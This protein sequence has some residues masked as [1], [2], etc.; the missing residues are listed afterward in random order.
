MFPEWALPLSTL[1]IVVATFVYSA[2]ARRALK[3]NGSGLQN[4][5][6]RIERRLERIE[7][8]LNEHLSWHLGNDR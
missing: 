4:S 7:E 2:I 1:V 8:R 6:E 3:K 5:L